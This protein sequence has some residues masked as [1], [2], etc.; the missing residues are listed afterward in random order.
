MHRKGGRE[1]RTTE[2]PDNLADTRVI[3]R[4]ADRA[5][6][7]RRVKLAVGTWRG[8]DLVQ[9]ISRGDSTG[10]V[11]VIASDIGLINSPPA[12]EP[13]PTGGYAVAFETNTAAP[14]LPY[15]FDHHLF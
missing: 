4:L 8:Y 12:I 6:Q 14:D 15:N 7:I 3:G 2:L 5:A 11:F 9:Q 13:L 10:E 1:P